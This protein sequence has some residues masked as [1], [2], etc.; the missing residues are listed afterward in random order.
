MKQKMNKAVKT[1]G[2]MFIMILLAKVLGQAREM[3]V[4]A[5]FGVGSLTDAYYA[6]STLP[7]NLFD[8]V[9]ASSI[10]SAFIPVYNTYIEKYGNEEG[11]RF[12]SGFVNTILLLSVVLCVLLIVFSKQL[13]GVLAG[14][15][16]EKTAEL[17]SSLTKI[18]MPIIVFASLTFSFTGILQS[19]GEFNIPAIISIVSNAVVI[20]YMIFLSDKFGIYGLSLS[21][22]IGWILQF[23]VQLP[24]AKKVGFSYKRVLYHKGLKDVVKL[25]LP[26]LVGTWIQ[27]ISNLINNAYASSIDNGISALNYA[28]KLF[29]IVAS[30]FTVSVTNY[31]F[32]LLSKQSATEDNKNYKKTLYNSFKIILIVLVPICVFMLS[33]STPIIELVYKRGQFDDNAVRLTAGAFY[34]YCFGII[35]YGVLDLFNKA[36]YALKNSVVPAVIAGSAIVLNGVLSYFL[37]NVM[38]IFGL[39]LSSTL[40]YFYMALMLFMSLN[41]RIKFFEIKNTLFIIKELLYGAVTFFVTV[42]C[43]KLLSAL[44]SNLILKITRMGLSALSGL[45]VYLILIVLFEKNTLKEMTKGAENELQRENKQN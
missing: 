19:K 16:D 25:A 17:A 24:S 8:I 11:N 4:A 33:L 12:A 21:L 32:P 41:K 3:F 37:K 31:V 30:V 44:D 10:S 2:F 27:P 28:S 36:F 7:L 34:Y 26:V 15:L 13:V 9:F 42:N 38:G 1:V 5:V 22:T 23:L 29:L 40:V 14:G 43:Y 35:F 45:V 6:A 18:M 20:I 39:A